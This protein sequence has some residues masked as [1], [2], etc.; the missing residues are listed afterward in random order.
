[1]E[2]F[3]KVSAIYSPQRTD[4]LIP[5]MEKYIG[6]RMMFEASW[7]IEEDTR[8]DGAYV[9]EYAMYF[10]DYEQEP[11]VLMGRW[12]PESDLKE[13]EVIQEGILFTPLP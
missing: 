13:I 5:G 7:I 4:D 9:G 3:A 2:K 11:D 10:I 6:Q 1:M 12:V 8:S